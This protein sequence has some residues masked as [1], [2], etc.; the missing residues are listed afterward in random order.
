MEGKLKWVGVNKDE[1]NDAEDEGS[2]GS[3]EGKGNLPQIYNLPSSL[4]AEEHS[5]PV[6]ISA[7]ECKPSTFLNSLT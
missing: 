1:L 4:M 2:A 6:V 3:Q 7:M 5:A